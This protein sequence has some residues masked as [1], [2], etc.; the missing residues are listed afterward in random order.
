MTLAL[1]MTA[2]VEST[3]RPVTVPVVICANDEAGNRNKA[4]TPQTTKLLM[5]RSIFLSLLF[6]GPVAHA[7]ARACWSAQFS[8]TVGVIYPSGPADAARARMNAPT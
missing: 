1:V 6:L 7:D 5:L 3:T 8:S 2:P 4:A